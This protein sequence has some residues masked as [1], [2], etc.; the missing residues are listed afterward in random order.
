MSPCEDYIEGGTG[1]PVGS[2]ED[3]FLVSPF[4]PDLPVPRDHFV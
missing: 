3:V 4:P 2:Q 1:S